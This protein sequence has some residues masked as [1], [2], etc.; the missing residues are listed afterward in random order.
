VIATSKPVPIKHM[1]ASPA[2]TPAQATAVQ[3]YLLGLETAKEAASRLGAFKVGGFLPFD[4]A[5]LKALG[6]WLDV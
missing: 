2:V 6:E 1:L 3:D 5:Q 4:A